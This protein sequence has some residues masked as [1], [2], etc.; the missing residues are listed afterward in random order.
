M[1]FKE[2]LEVLHPYTDI[3][4]ET[5]DA[6]YY[7]KTSKPGLLAGNHKDYYDEHKN[8]DVDY[9]YP[10]HSDTDGNHMIIKITDKPKHVCYFEELQ[11]DNSRFYCVECGNSIPNLY[12]GL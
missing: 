11:H 10:D 9:A 5:D 7:F 8:W 1:K 12:R 3:N 6:I 4:V 2:L